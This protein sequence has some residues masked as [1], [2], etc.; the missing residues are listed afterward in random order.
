MS[1]S[2][3]NPPEK[4]FIVVLKRTAGNKVPKLTKSTEKL[5]F[6]P[7]DAIAVRDELNKDCADSSHWAV[8][9]VDVIVDE[10]VDQAWLAKNE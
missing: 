6:M 7:G 10:E 1:E 3:E 2:L 9:T 4:A 5:F 8:Y